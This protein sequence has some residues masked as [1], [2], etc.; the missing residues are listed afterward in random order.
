MP[1]QSAKARKTKALVGYFI[2]VLLLLRRGE[3]KWASKAPLTGA[4]IRL[5]K[6]ERGAARCR[7]SL[8]KIRAPT[9]AWRRQAEISVLEMVYRRQF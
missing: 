7:T 1:A 5:E 3:N 8:V 4:V 2:G 6:T 9:T